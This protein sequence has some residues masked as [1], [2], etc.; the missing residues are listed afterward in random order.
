MILNTSEF[1]SK[2]AVACSGNSLWIHQ[3]SASRHFPCRPALDRCK[4]VLKLVN[5]AQIG[6]VYTGLTAAASSRISM[7]SLVSLL[8]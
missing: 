3:Q 7:S 8:R 2:F 1:K 5:M 4:I 6:L